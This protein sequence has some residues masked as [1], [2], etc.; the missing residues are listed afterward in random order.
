MATTI[1]QVTYSNTNRRSA[2]SQ[3]TRARTAMDRCFG[4]VRPH[5]RGIVV[6]QKWDYKPF[7]VCPLLLRRV[8]SAPLSASSTQHMSELLDGNAARQFLIYVTT[9]KASDTLERQPTVWP[10]LKNG[11]SHIIWGR[12]GQNSKRSYFFTSLLAKIDTHIRSYPKVSKM[13]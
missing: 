12:F 2:H 4:L 9:V 10:F 7:A 13:L 1:K 8:Q 11:E 3:I 5:Q 6:G